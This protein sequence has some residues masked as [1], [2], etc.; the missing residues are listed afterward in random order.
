ML[1]RPTAVSTVNQRL[2]FGMQY[3]IFMGGSVDCHTSFLNFV[4]FT[5]RLVPTGLRPKLS[6]AAIGIVIVWPMP[7]GFGVGMSGGIYWNMH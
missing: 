3:R 2:L 1:D 7:V 5:D 6:I 4:K